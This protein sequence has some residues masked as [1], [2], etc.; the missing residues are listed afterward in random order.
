MTDYEQFIELYNKAVN[1][2]LENS[3]NEKKYYDEY[4]IKGTQEQKDFAMQ[5]K[6]EIDKTDKKMLEKFND[7]K[8]ILSCY[9]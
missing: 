2:Y 8:E 3:F 1:S 7:V 5:R 4:I 6:K 9:L